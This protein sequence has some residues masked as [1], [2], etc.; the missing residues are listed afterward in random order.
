[1]KVT[2]NLVLCHIVGMNP[3]I[4]DSFMINLKTMIELE[5]ID[6]DYIS[7]KIFNSRKMKELYKIFEPIKHKKNKKAKDAEKEITNFWLEQMKVKLEEEIYR[8][9]EKE[10][11][12]L[13]RITITNTLEEKL[14]FQLIII[15]LSKIMLVEMLNVLSDLI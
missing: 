9:R 14:K 11:M 1:M 4:K 13:V 7:D 2:N 6:L 5:I 12:L 8:Y 15:T 10:I 3:E